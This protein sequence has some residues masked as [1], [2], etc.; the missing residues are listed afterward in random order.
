MVKSLPIPNNHVIIKGRT[1]IV[2]ALAKAKA[3][4]KQGA[5]FRAGL[6]LDA[7]TYGTLMCIMLMHRMGWGIQYTVPQYQ[8]FLYHKI[9]VLTTGICDVQVIQNHLLL[10]KFIHLSYRIITIWESKCMRSLW[11]GI[12]NQCNSIVTSFGFNIESGVVHGYTRDADSMVFSQLQLGRKSIN[13]FVAGSFHVVGWID[14]NGSH[15]RIL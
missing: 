12:P 1:P 4:S 6:H 15:A 13:K 5:V 3:N 7:G 8:I 9:D 10:E 2:S 11:V 14:D